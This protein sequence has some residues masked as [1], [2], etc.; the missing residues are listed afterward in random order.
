M[1]AAIYFT[2]PRDAALTKLAASWFGRDAFARVQNKA[3]DP[4]IAPFITAPSRYGFHATLKAPW[5]LRPDVSLD[6]VDQHLASFCAGR[7]GVMINALSL[8]LLD[9]FYAL[10][11]EQETPA[12]R[13]LERDTLTSFDVF[14][15]PPTPEEIARRR[16]ESL[17]ERQ[18]RYLKAWGYPFV[19]DEFRFHMT[20]TNAMRLACDAKRVGA[21]L[22][23]HF[24][25]AL[26]APLLI[27]GLALF[28]EP[29]PGHAFHIHACH[30][31]SGG[32]DT[33]PRASHV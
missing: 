10:V 13:E 20:L 22:R 32:D 2:P 8:A 27:D 1:R 4:S 12:L 17:T 28:I 19:L 11:P 9:D 31:F 29:A 3:P 16:P 15:A 23:S 26:G 33:T 7:R 14:R 5:R 30:R 18:L 6:E 25:S 21:A 24:A